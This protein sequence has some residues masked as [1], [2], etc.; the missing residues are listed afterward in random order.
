M[1]RL[2]IDDQEITVPEGTMIA[3]AA[4]KL[5]IDVPVYCYHEALGPLGACRMC[6]VQ[7]EK[8]PK[9]ATACTTAVGE[10]MVVH[11]K[12]PAVD[13]GRKGV[14]EFLLI[15]H[16]LD[17]PVCDKGGECFLQDYTFQYG[18]PQGRF[19]EPK[20]QKVKDGP[21]NEFILV[22]QERC[23]LCQRCVRFM[24]EYVG[25]PQLLLDGRGVETVVATVDGKPATSQFSGNVIDLCPVGALL[26]VPYHHK[27]RPWN[28][29]REEAVCTLCPVGCTTLNTGRDGHIVRVEGRPVPDR[30][31]GW[32]C[33][34][35]RFGYDFAIHP[36]RLTSSLLNGQPEAAAR[37]TRQVGQWLFDVVNEHGGESVAFVVGG[38]HSTEEAYQLRR[39]AEDVVGTSRLAVSRLEAGYLPRGLNGTFEDIDQADAVVLV[40]ADPY[41]AVPVV[42]LR[43]RDRVR[44]FPGL[45]LMGVAPRDLGRETLSVD[46]VVTHVGHEAATLAEALKQVAGD[47]PSVAA[48]HAPEVPGLDQASIEPLAK[49]LTESEHL[50]LLWDGLEADVEAVLVALARVRGDK[51]T[52]VLPTWGPSN[53]RGFERAGF[54][55]R[56]N[57]LTQ[58]LHD[59][60]D[61]KIHM[62]VVWGADLMREYPDRALVEAA[63]EKVPVLVAEGLFAPLG[64]EHFQAILPQ[65]APGE[66]YGTYVNMEARLQVAM[67][68]VQPPGQARP[69]KTYVT[70]WAHAL[71]K[72]LPL[73][74]DWDPYDDNSG[75]LL[76]EE[77][78][79]GLE[80]RALGA[81]DTPEAGAVEVI[82]GSLVIENGIPSDILKPRIPSFPGRISADLAERLGIHE[83]GTVRVSRNQRSLAVP[84]AVDPQLTPGRIFIPL[85]SGPLA[86]NQI[87]LGA[88]NVTVQEE[89]PSA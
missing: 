66:V 15:N 85:A 35:G 9:L 72:S 57:D 22:D 67:P 43:L 68:S 39:F 33:D 49:A 79:D 20:I 37:T 44:A 47:D 13:K 7:V 30:S 27:A 54:S 64:Q 82:S 48:L 12:N 11:T 14:L 58:I 88:A 46:T 28:I 86:V 10:G 52:R 21:I 50:V 89:V 18:P 2:T 84:V 53:W 62:L 63:F 60:I 5:G 42:H 70:T 45:K 81:I 77:S 32:L 6:L 19:Q 80:V 87:G 23:V 29:E 41:E 31:W 69:T 74:E 83:H 8:M 1:I 51:A 56:L 17:C 59:A 76:P 34:R 61:G 4:A 71:K 75:D 55:A 26:S 65:A 16:P 38:L 78:L 36:D 24:G 3:D 40:G 73:P 25:E